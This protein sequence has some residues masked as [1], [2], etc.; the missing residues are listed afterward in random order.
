[1]ALADGHFPKAWRGGQ[2]SLCALAAAPRNVVGCRRCG[3]LWT[4]AIGWPRQRLLVA[5]TPGGQLWAAGPGQAL[6]SFQGPRGAPRRIA[7]AEVV[8]GAPEG[9]YAFC[10]DAFF[11]T[12]RLP[13]SLKRS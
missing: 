9:A 4:A 11:L 13:L 2:A 8:A 1:M 3:A 7:S 10:F 5:G 12:E 6:R